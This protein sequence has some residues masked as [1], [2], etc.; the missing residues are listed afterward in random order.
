[1]K[2]HLWVLKCDVEGDFRAVRV[3]AD[4]LVLE[5]VVLD[6]MW[7]VVVT[8]PHGA[9]DAVENV[10]ADRHEFVHVRRDELEHAGNGPHLGRQLR[11]REPP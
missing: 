4:A 8:V 5:S 3:H 7:L 2:V 1:M 6:E 11:G 10:F 9:R